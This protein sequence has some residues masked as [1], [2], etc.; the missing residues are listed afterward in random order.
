MA[1]RLRILS[2]ATPSSSS[3]SRRKERKEG[4]GGVLE[5][6][7]RVHRDVLEQARGGDLHGAIRSLTPA[8]ARFPR[9]THL[10]TTSASLLDRAGRTEEAVD[11]LRQACAIDG[12]DAAP[13]QA[14]A[15]L[16]SRRGDF[17]SAEAL[18]ERATLEE[19]NGNAAKAAELDNQLSEIEAMQRGVFRGTP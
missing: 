9:N 18:F 5:D 14:W 15:M 7:K 12:T 2:S 17:A 19:T 13:W 16:A 3:S 10:L 4:E 11:A 8:L 1:A 6:A